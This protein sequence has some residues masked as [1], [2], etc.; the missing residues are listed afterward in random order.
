MMLVLWALVF[1][2]LTGIAVYLYLVIKSYEA[3]GFWRFKVEK[4]NI[5]VFVYPKWLLGWI[6]WTGKKVNK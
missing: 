6:Y 2:V 1:Y 3:I 5:G 4:D